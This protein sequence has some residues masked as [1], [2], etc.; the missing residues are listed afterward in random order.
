MNI[1][2]INLNLLLLLKT[3]FEEKNTTKAA[4]IL[5]ITQS[6][7]SQGLKK[8]RSI[9]SDKLLI[10]EKKSEKATLTPKALSLKLDVLKILNNAEQIFCAK[11]K[12]I[13]YLTDKTYF[14]AMADLI[15]S[16]LLP[17]M[18]N[19][20][21][22]T[23]PKA[24]ISVDSLDSYYEQDLASL[25]ALDIVFCSSITTPPSFNSEAICKSRLVVAASIANAK[26]SKVKNIDELR[27]FRH[28]II[29]HGKDKMHMGTALD[30]YRALFDFANEISFIQTPYINSAIRMIEK[31]NCVVIGSEVLL[32]RIVKDYKI[33]I[34]PVEFNMP[35]KT[36]MCWHKKKHDLPYHKW[37]RNTAKEAFLRAFGL[38]T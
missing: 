6:S 17:E 37:L 14:I 30:D 25:E 15:S 27:S 20:F 9:F 24:K 7:A 26:A 34:L 32:S 1:S 19:T 10:W 4:Q 13:P 36:W 12:F 31:S 2:D 28:I 23:A 18:I 35:T 5:N 22:S 11:N 38:K 16:Y 21:R 8:L 29:S 3:L 33:K